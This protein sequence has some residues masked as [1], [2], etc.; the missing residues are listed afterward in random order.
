VD[1]RFSPS[2]SQEDSLPDMID[3]SVDDCK[4]IDA[5]YSAP[6]TLSISYL[7]EEMVVEDDSSLF[8]QEVPHD[9]FSPGIEEKNLE[10]SHFLVKN[11]RVVHSPIFEE[12]SD[13]EEKIPTSC[14]VD[15]GSNQPVYDGYESDSDVEINHPGSTDD[16]QQHVK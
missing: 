8:L 9:V 12:Y 13:E 16:I 15:L 7:K 3:D 1:E 10:V 14:F 4:S 6:S 5:L 11:K 2:I